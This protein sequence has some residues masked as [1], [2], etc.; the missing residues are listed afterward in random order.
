MVRP[1]EQ[2]QRQQQTRLKAD[3]EVFYPSTLM[4]IDECVSACFGHASAAFR[5]SNSCSSAFGR[6]CGRFCWGACSKKKGW[7]EELL[8]RWRLRTPP[9]ECFIRLREKRHGTR[10]YSRSGAFGRRRGSLFRFRD[11]LLRLGAL[12]LCVV[13]LGERSIASGSEQ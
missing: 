2:Q 13:N 9:R 8:P 11:F 4:L 5:N 1:A 12:S 7:D 3:S 10:S 6:R